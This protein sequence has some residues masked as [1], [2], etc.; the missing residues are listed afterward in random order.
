MMSFSC[1]CPRRLTSLSDQAVR[2]TTKDK[3]EAKLDEMGLTVMADIFDGGAGD[4]V[5]SLSLLE[6]HQFR[7]AIMF[8]YWL[9]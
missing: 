2:W 5:F 3:V 7:G 4:D 1:S 9:I 8:M 6:A